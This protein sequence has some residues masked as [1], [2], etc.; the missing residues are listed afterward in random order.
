MEKVV[1]YC[2]RTRLASAR[3]SLTTWSK[4][5]SIASEICY[6]GRDYPLLLDEVSEGRAP[7][8][9]FAGKKIA[10][11]TQAMRLGTRDWRAY[12]PTHTRSRR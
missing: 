11:D 12:L 3:R 1:A 2:Q 9:L 7:L 5:P 6:T 10:R 4:P 8:S